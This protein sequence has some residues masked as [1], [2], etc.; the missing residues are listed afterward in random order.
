MMSNFHICLFILISTCIHFVVKC[1]ELTK[2]EDDSKP[3]GIVN[4]QTS[5]NP[6][7]AE[8]FNTALSMLY[9]FWYI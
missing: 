2:I 9:S 5:C 8:Q 1:D 3:Y 7:V 4:F 6:N